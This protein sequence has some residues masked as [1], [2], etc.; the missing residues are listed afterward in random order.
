MLSD[1]TTFKKSTTSVFPKKW[2]ARKKYKQFLTP[3]WVGGGGVVLT[4]KMGM[5]VPPYV[6]KK[7]AYGTDQTEKVCVF[8]TERTVKVVPLELIELGKMG[9]FRK[10]GWF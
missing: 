1:F 3:V 10:S 6:K 2:N 8:R 7:G 4:C 5:Y 9:A